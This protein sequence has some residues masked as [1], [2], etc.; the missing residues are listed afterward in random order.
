[1]RLAP[2]PFA[3]AALA[4]LTS[5][6]TVNSLERNVIEICPLSFFADSTSSNRTVR[7]WQPTIGRFMRYASLPVE[8]LAIAWTHDA[9]SLVASCTDGAIRVI[10]PQEVVVTKTI[11]VG[12]DWLY[13]IEAAPDE[14]AVA[15]GDGKGRV[16]R[17]LLNR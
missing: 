2:A 11:T 4:S 13:A 9:S 3:F 14:Y 12:E 6:Y 8:P 17:V 16:Q 5:A 1:M 10:D 7:F 15:V